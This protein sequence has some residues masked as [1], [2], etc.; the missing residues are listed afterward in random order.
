MFPFPLILCNIIEQIAHWKLVS[1]SFGK[2]FPFVFLRV[3]SNKTTISTSQSGTKLNYVLFRVRIRKRVNLSIIFGLVPTSTFISWT[4]FCRKC[5]V[6][7]R[8][9]RT[10]GVMTVTHLQW[11]WMWIHLNWLCFYVFPQLSNPRQR[12]RG[13][14]GYCHR[15]GGHHTPHH[16]LLYML[17]TPS[18]WTHLL[19]MCYTCTVEPLIKGHLIEIL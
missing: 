4:Q 12:S 17:T 8:S 5:S 6:E 18:K 15:L 9:F 7:Q 11:S 14:L 16:F 1:I 3:K 10:V 2:S 19:W 13:F